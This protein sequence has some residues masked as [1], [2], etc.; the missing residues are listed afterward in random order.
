MRLT[1]TD[2]EAYRNE[3]QTQLEKEIKARSEVEA[4]ISAMTAELDA[5]AARRPRNELSTTLISHLVGL[6][7]EAHM[8]IRQCEA[9]FQILQE[10]MPS[11][12]KYTAPSRYPINKIHW[13]IASLNDHH[14]FAF[15]SKSSSYGLFFDGST[16]IG[17]HLWAAMLI[18]EE[19]EAFV[20]DCKEGLS[21]KSADNC[22]GFIEMIQDLSMRLA[23]YQLIDDPVAFVKDQLSKINM[24]LSDSCPEAK[25]TRVLISNMIKATVGDDD[26]IIILG[27]CTMHQVC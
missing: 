8:S 18:N 15:M 26:M 23:A 13:T 21:S 10:S 20:I 1:G 4:K 7:V 3:M 22:D 11:L 14:A 9:E 24:V 19:G 17:K 12:A 6:T 25:L 16:K 5:F 27:D 2:I